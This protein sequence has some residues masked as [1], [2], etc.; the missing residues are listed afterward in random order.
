MFDNRCLDSDYRPLRPTAGNDSGTCGAYPTW[1][2]IVS[3]GAILLFLVLAAAFVSYDPI[4]PSCRPACLMSRTGWHLQSKQ[5]RRRLDL[6]LGPNQ[7]PR[8]ASEMRVQW[9]GSHDT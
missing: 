3:A 7:N 9:R 1:E 4:Q 2:W 6:K 5:I 8:L